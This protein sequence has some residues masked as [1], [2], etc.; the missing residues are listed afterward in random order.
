MA[1][2]FGPKKGFTPLSPPS[3]PLLLEAPCPITLC[4]LR[5]GEKLWELSRSGGILDRRLLVR[6]PGGRR[7][8]RRTARSRCA[9]SDA[10][11]NFGSFQGAAV[12]S[13]GGLLGCPPCYAIAWVRDRFR[14]FSP[15]SVINARRNF[16]IAAACNCRMRSRVRPMF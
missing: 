5:C 9:R 10:V 15:L 14:L 7:S 16:V 2:L 4:A 6:R 3:N 1:V 11:K 12:S 8:L 13:T